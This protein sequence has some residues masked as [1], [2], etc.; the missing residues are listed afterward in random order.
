MLITPV[1]D[2]GSA[3]AGSAAVRQS[4]HMDRAST[5]STSI[6]EALPGD[7]VGTRADWLRAGISERTFAD[8]R[9]RRIARGLYVA[10]GDDR[11]LT[12]SRLSSLLPDDAVIGGWA[13]AAA[14]G[15]RDASPTMLRAR[16]DDVL[17]YPGRHQHKKMPGFQVLRSDVPDSE[18]EVVD[19]MRLTCPARTA[20]DMARFSPSLIA[21][22][23]LLDCFLFE[24][25]TRVLSPSEVQVLLE[26]HSRSRG[27]ARVRAALPMSSSRSRSVPESQLRAR[28]IRDCGFVATDL[29]VN[30]SARLGDARYE[31]DLLDM[32]TGLVL[33]Y[34]GH[35]HADADQRARD[36]RKDIAVDDAG[37]VMMRVNAPLLGNVVELARTV[38]RRRRSASARGSLGALA[39][40]ADGGLVSQPPL[41][42]Y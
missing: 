30:V 40:L 39:K 14:Y 8:G 33:E 15:V 24:G 41:T 27:N 28:L 36:S 23:G 17:V 9:L 42:I 10:A 18:I 32:T 7:G 25:N 11:P 6:I 20:Y 12:A 38:E 2:W 35:H 13:A 22:V 31:L 3:R 34:D 21:A 16:P 5:I 19:G 4:G 37:L 26:E 1:D 29:A